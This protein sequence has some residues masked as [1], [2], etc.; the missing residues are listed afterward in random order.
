M[1]DRLSDQL[2]T[3]AVRP[4]FDPAFAARVQA[5]LTASRAEPTLLFRLAAAGCLLAAVIV[6]VSGGLRVNHLQSTDM[7]AASYARS[8]DPLQL[9]DAH[10][11]HSH[12]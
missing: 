1:Q 9:A 7:A 5:R 2:Q 8:I 4:E 10:A 12:P 6:G 11:G 3:W